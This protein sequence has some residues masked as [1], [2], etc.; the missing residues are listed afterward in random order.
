MRVD[1]V[2]DREAAAEIAA[3]RR[4]SLVRV[5]KRRR[6]SDA[7]LTRDQVF[8]A[9]A[10]YWRGGLSIPELAA[11]LS[12]DDSALRRAFERH[13][14]RIRSKSAATLLVVQGRGCARCGCPLDERTVG[15]G[16]CTSRHHYR[17]TLAR[18]A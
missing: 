5:R 4:P 10:L 3:G 13:G 17:R 11:K 15:C 2:S 9:H 16:R 6:R 14:L 7:K 1:G 18:A 12:M 8:A